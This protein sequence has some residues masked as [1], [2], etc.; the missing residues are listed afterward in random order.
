[1]RIKRLYGPRGFTTRGRLG[2]LLRQYESNTYGL[3][4]SALGDIIYLDAIPLK[5][6][7]EI[8]DL[9]PEANR[10]DSQNDSPSLLQ[11]AAME[12]PG[13][14]F[15]GYRVVPQR[16]D[17]RVTIEGFYCLPRYS[18]DALALCSH[19]PN[20]A[21]VINHPKLGRVFRAWWD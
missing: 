7:R 18:E 3:P 16:D 14:H 21:W 8:W 10:G 19:P 17:E 20:E 11:F 4:P 13:I 6:L 1:M 5:A 12:T 15:H 2:K 9:L